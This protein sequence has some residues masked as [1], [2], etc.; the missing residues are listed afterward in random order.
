MKVFRQYISGSSVIKL[1]LESPAW[2]LEIFVEEEILDKAGDHL[3][4]GEIP[5]NMLI[6]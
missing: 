2:E 5:E 1:N 6:T 3:L 4:L